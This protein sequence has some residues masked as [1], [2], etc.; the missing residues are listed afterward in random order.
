MSLEEYCLQV[1]TDLWIFH[2]LAH[3]V[4][5]GNPLW[6]CHLLLSCQEK[7]PAHP[8]L[9]NTHNKLKRQNLGEN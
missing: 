6:K 8:S 3:A 9:Q 4:K 1:I 7:T 5:Y 2:L